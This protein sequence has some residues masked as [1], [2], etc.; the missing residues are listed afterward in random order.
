[1]FIRPLFLLITTTLLFGCEAPLVMDGVL[2][3]KVSPVRRTDIFMSAVTS[4]N[5]SIIVGSEGVVISADSGTNGWQRNQLEGKPALIDITS[6]SQGLLAALTMGGEVWTSTDQAQ[7]WKSHRLATEEVPQAI[8][9]DKEDVIWVVGSFSTILS[10]SDSGESWISHSLEEDMILSTIQF[11]GES[12][13][14]ITG[15]FGT[16][17]VTEDGGETW[18]FGEPIPNEFFPLTSIFKN[19]QQGWVAGLNS[20]IYS[21]IDGGNSW[22][23]QET[24]STAPLYGLSILNDEV[25][26]V[27][28]YG[29]IIYKNINSKSNNLWEILD[30][31]VQSRSF[32]RVSMPLN[33]NKMIIAGGAGTLELIDL[34]KNNIKGVEIK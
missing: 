14:I 24:A 16:V 9:C 11:L 19:S 4:G 28:D 32:F 2:S 23:L 31:S 12:K 5:K 8:T 13:G 34:G 27:G 20:I 7:S 22:Q 21:T 33:D 18:N 30:V 29:T 15:E 10:S 6:C 1:M 26:A 25:I 3:N 17:L